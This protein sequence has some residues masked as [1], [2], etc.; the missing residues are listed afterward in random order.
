MFGGEC[1]SSYRNPIKRTNST[2]IPASFSDIFEVVPE[3]LEGAKEQHVVLEPHNNFQV[4][5]Q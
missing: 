4:I 3:R 1:L 2:P 5:E